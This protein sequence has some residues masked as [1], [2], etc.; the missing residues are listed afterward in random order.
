M[1][2]A[3]PSQCSK[4][5]D[6][7]NQKGSLTVE[8][9]EAHWGTN[10]NYEQTLKRRGHVRG[11][12]ANSEEYRNPYSGDTFPLYTFNTETPWT[13]FINGTPS[14]ELYTLE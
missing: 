1:H 3:S 7:L 5:C 13:E 4:I 11:V 10:T 2:H 12:L 6:L 8:D 9:F 14:S